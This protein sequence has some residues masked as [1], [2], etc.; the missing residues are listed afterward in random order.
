MH[1]HAVA[2]ASQP[3]QSISPNSA[4]AP[5]QTQNAARQPKWSPDLG[6][7]ALSHAHCLRPCAHRWALHSHAAPR[8]PP[9]LLRS[10]HT[11]PRTC[12]TLADSCSSCCCRRSISGGI[13]P[14]PAPP[15]PT[16]YTPAAVLPLARRPGAARGA[17]PAPPQPA[18]A[19]RGCMQGHGQHKYSGIWVAA[20]TQGRK[21][22]LDWPVAA[23]H[24]KST[25]LTD[26]PE[27]EL[28]LDRHCHCTGLA[29][30]WP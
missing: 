30:C 22:A 6:L 25:L 8:P 13:A 1:H 19:G 26:E 18:L 7:C 11:T 14:P 12:C 15:K 28:V 5:S 16:P 10:T 4:E 21:K 2:D 3:P 17:P 20:S 9:Q 24:S 27:Y 23:Q 29:R